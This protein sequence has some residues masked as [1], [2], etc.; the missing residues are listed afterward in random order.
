MVWDEPRMKDLHSRSSI[1]EQIFYLHGSAQITKNNLNR[2]RNNRWQKIFQPLPD[3]IE[4]SVQWEQRLAVEHATTGPLK[5]WLVLL[6]A[7]CQQLSSGETLLRPQK[8]KNVFYIYNFSHIC[9]YAH[10]N[11]DLSLQKGKSPKWLMTIHCVI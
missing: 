2:T 7:S 11:D 3:G 9:T 8:Q 4:P 6:I 10:V 1:N 5:I